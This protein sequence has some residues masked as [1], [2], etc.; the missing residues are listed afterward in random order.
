[1]SMGEV[2]GMIKWSVEWLSSSGVRG[3]ELVSIDEGEA[4][5]L[6]VDLAVGLN[7]SVSDDA[8]GIV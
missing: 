2:I 1:M 7:Q 4:E 6:S 5:S 3:W 8:L